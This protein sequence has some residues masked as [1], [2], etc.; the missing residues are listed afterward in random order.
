MVF[1]GRERKRERGQTQ[2]FESTRDSTGIYIHVE[3]YWKLCRTAPVLNE[4]WSEWME[5]CLIRI[6]MTREWRDMQNCIKCWRGTPVG[7]IV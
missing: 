6:V 1:G 3:M 7:K 2:K 5:N 4:D